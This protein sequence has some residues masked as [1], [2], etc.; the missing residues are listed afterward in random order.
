MAKNIR[1]FFGEF[2]WL[3]SEYYYECQLLWWLEIWILLSTTLK[4]CYKQA[5]SKELKLMGGAMNY[6]SKKYW[7]VKYFGLWSPGLRN[8]FWKICKFVIAK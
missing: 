4:Y 3:F 2:N 1:G 6:F 7:T 5:L 8:I